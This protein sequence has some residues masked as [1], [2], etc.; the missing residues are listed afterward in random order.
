MLS[1]ARPVIVTERM[2][3]STQPLLDPAGQGVRPWQLA[4]ASAVLEVHQ[5]P[6]TQRGWTPSPSGWSHSPARVFRL[7]GEG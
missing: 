1:L 3:E 4:D 5:D 2:R 7:I 6:A